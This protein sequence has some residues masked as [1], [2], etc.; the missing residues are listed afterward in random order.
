MEAVQ[1]KCYISLTCTRL[2]GPH[3]GLNHVTVSYG[4]K[5]TTPV[6]PQWADQ[7]QSPLFPQPLISGST[8]IPPHALS[9]IVRNISSA[10]ARRSLCSKTQY[11]TFFIVLR[12]AVKRQSR[13]GQCQPGAAPLVAR[14]LFYKPPF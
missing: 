10:P 7:P 5:V 9:N 4:Q 14:R 12:A 6:T 3:W 2:S 8:L 13:A 11:C 1:S